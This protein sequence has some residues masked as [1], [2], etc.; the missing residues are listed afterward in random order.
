MVSCKKLH[1]ILY[2]TV[3][4]CSTVVGM[5]QIVHLPPTCTQIPTGIITYLRSLPH[6]YTTAGTIIEKAQEITRFLCAFSNTRG[7]K[8]TLKGVDTL[9]S[10][11]AEFVRADKPIEGV[12]VAFPAKSSNTETKVLQSKTIDMAECASLLTLYHICKEISAIHAPGATIGIWSREAHIYELNKVTQQHLNIPLFDEN[13]IEH[14]Q[15][16]L[17]SLVTL[18]EPHL[19]LINIPNTRAVFEASYAQLPVQPAY[20]V[21][22]YATFFKEELNQ[23]KIEEAI[24]TKQYLQQYKEFSNKPSFAFIKP[25]TSWQA[26]KDASAANAVTKKQFEKFKNQIPRKS[27]INTLA[28]ELAIAVTLGSSRNRALLEASV[29]NYNACIRLSVSPDNEGNVGK[30]LGINLIYKARGTPWHNALAITNNGIEFGPRST[31][32]NKQDVLVQ[33][34]KYYMAKN[35][36]LAYSDAQTE[37]NAEDQELQNN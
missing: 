2:T 9:T 36:A 29:P 1:A 10:K 19:K 25:Y 21:E 37:L 5:D 11:I 34:L 33:T 12:L 14:Y 20:N 22:D 24:F 18:F 16:D 23:I 13:D 27:V 4:V 30:K 3:L 28:S 35:L 8:V 31:F 6:I 32:T 15:K 7:G 17:E 26:F